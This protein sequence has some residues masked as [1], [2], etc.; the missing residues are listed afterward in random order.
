MELHNGKE[1][2]NIEQA[3]FKS[4]LLGPARV[5]DPWLEVTLDY[6]NLLS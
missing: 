3:A 5:V 2:E 1:I 6:W 4:W